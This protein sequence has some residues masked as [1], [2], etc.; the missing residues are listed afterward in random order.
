MWCLAYTSCESCVTE[1]KVAELIEEMR[2]LKEKV[3]TLEKKLDANAKQEKNEFKVVVT[4]QE[5]KTEIHKTGV[6]KVGGIRNR[7]MRNFESKS[8]NGKKIKSK[9]LTICYILSI[10]IRSWKF[11]IVFPIVYAETQFD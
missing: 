11:T 10:D 2:A 9:C 3:L 1:S 4:N 7:T 8:I 5:N 6:S